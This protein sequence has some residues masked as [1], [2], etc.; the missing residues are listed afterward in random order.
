MSGPDRLDVHLV[1]PMAGHGSR[2]KSAG[3]DLPKPLIPLLGQPFFWWAAESV[4]RHC[5]VRS[6]TFVVLQEHVDRHRIDQ[7]VLARYPEARLVVLPEPTSGALVTA[8]AG[9]EAAP[10]S[11][12]LVINDC[13]HVFSGPDLAR[14][15]YACGGQADAFLLHFRSSSPAFSYGAYSPDGRLLRTREKEPISDLAIA[16]AYGFRDRRFFLD[17]GAAYLVDCP[18]AEPFMSGVYNTVVAAGGTVRGIVLG[19]HV[20][21]G[22]PKEFEA[23]PAA[24]GEF[25]SWGAAAPDTSR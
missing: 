9:C 10:E 16:G 4:E 7:E 13:D 20:P 18:Y 25:R 5:D 11:G 19:Q 24:M 1:M 17:N 6:R 15:A 2:F 12:W 3:F 22:T 8:V 21:F 14:Q 23:A